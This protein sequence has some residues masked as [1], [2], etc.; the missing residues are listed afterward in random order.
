MTDKQTNDPLI[1][2][3]IDGRYEILELIGKGGFG[4]VYKAK[5]LQV[6]NIVAIKV[7]RAEYVEDKR[8]A[9]RFQNEAKIAGH[10]PNRHITK[11]FDQGRCDKTNV[12]Y[13]AMEYV[14][15]PSL[16]ELINQKEGINTETS[17]DILIQ[18]CDGI[19]A[20]HN[21]NILHRDIKPSNIILT[22]Y[23]NNPYFVKITDFGIATVLQESEE[24]KR[25]TNTE[26]ANPQGTCLYMAPEQYNKG[27]KAA[28]SLD[29]YSI[30]CVLFELFT[31]EAP[32]NGGS[33]AV[34]AH[35]HTTA[36]IPALEL[37]SVEPV[38]KSR[39]TDIVNK[40]L[41]KDPSMR[42]QSAKDLQTDLESVQLR[43]K[44]L[45]VHKA[46]IVLSTIELA[47]LLLLRMGRCSRFFFRKSNAQVLAIVAIVLIVLAAAIIMIFQ[48]K[49]A[50]DFVLP[51]DKRNIEWEA[52]PPAETATDRHLF[53]DKEKQFLEIEGTYRTFGKLSTAEGLPLLRKFGYFYLKSES[54]VKAFQQFYKAQELL[55]SKHINDPNESAKVY[56]ALTE[57]SFAM[58]N[59]PQCISYAQKTLST[60]KPLEISDYTQFAHGSIE[61]LQ[62][63]GR[64][65]ILNKNPTLANFAFSEM[66]TIGSYKHLP[67]D[68][69]FFAVES[70]IHA[71]GF[72]Y[73]GSYFLSMGKFDLAETLLRYA[74]EGWH[75]SHNAINEAVTWNQL[76]LVFMKTNKYKEA[77]DAYKKAE[78]ILLSIGGPQ[79]SKLGK[80]LFNEADAQQAAGDT[81]GAQEA[82]KQARVYWFKSQG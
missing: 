48:N 21:K 62:Y 35:M 63:L 23:D 54:L 25:L 71:E 76:G 47:W 13:I 43:V 77:I 31:G 12:V 49:Y 8:I 61:A 16:K 44:Q 45:N 69:P 39:L 17:L 7:L 4:S 22:D 42:Y 70:E 36:K 50:Q 60:L 5:H 81:S 28:N 24:L 74:I 38:I 75:F 51:Q 2:K 59:Y 53:E 11:A 37:D 78:S 67:T 65:A 1:G 72:S 46:N 27:Y 73:A 82:R 79:A 66:Y 41:A 19:A 80:V 56:L 29:I 68:A 58:G 33:A 32:Y 26:T 10:I 55:V 20:A 6:K 57:C 15:G 30:G 9:A 18:L 52:P 40:T 34:T 3:I 14:P 64:A